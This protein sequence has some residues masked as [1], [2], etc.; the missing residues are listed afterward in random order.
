MTH[1]TIRAWADAGGQ[2]AEHPK[3]A[4]LLFIAGHERH[5]ARYA[6]LHHVSA[7]LRRLDGPD[8]L[9]SE[10]DEPR[11]SLLLWSA[12]LLI[13]DDLA[14]WFLSGLP[15]EHVQ[16]QRKAAGEVMHRPYLVDL[17]PATEPFRCMLSGRPGTI[18]LRIRHRSDESAP[19]VLLDPHA[20]IG[21]IGEGIAQLERG[22]DHLSDPDDTDRDGA[23]R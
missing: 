16:R 19:V 9:A 6:R 18:A 21:A 3:A 12:E 22:L 11:R 15:T 5:A 23:E 7:E 8:R 2:P 10:E 1:Q 13:D 20:V 14:D 4:E 17:V